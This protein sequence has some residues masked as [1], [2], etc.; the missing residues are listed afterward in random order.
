MS[1]QSE[2]VDVASVVGDVQ[3]SE[4]GTRVDVRLE[5]AGGSARIIVHDQGCGMAPSFL[6]FVFDPFRQADSTT[7]RAQGGLGLGLAIVKYLAE[8]HGGTVAAPSEGLGRGTTFTVTLPLAVRP[9]PSS[10]RRS[11]PISPACRS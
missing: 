3:F 5:H 9:V 6:P 8:A 7:T 4:R 2:P 1:L 11:C 10:T